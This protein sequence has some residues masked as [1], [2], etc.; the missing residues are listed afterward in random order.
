MVKTRNSWYEGYN[1]FIPSTNN[2]LEATNWVIKDEHTFRKPHSLSR[3]F[4]IAND[5][6]NNWSK[7]R[8]RNQIDPILFST[9]PTISLKKWTDAYH[10]AKSS[11]S[12]LQ[13]LTK[14]KGLTDYY[15]PAGET[16]N[17]TTNEIFC[18]EN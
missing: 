18:L 9:E 4:T 3:F 5:I 16:E 2:S 1:N 12:V 6:V 15:I 14:T 13:I 11:K 10:F 7:S 17:I 8:N